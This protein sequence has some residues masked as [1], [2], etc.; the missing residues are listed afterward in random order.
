[1]A[2]FFGTT[3]LTQLYFFSFHNFARSWLGCGVHQEVYVFL[4][5]QPE[6][7]FFDRALDFVNGPFVALGETVD[8][9]LSEQFFVSAL[10]P[11]S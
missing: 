9:A 8:L 3:R 10:P 2:Q 11:F 1:M 5:F 7:P 6:T 4:G